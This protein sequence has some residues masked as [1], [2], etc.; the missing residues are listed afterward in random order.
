MGDLA[1]AVLF[2]AAFGLGCWSLLAMTARWGA[3]SLV[4]RVA[5]YI[6]DVVGA[7]AGGA[8]A[9]GALGL[10]DSGGAVL[11]A[12]GARM[13]ERITSLLGGSASVERRLA[14]AGAVGGAGGVERF[15]GRQL[16]WGLLG[17]LAGAMLVVVLAVAG[18]LSAPGLAVPIIAGAGSMALC[19]A[20]LSAVARRRVTRITDELPTVLEFLSL[21]LA[22]GEGLLDSLRRV[23]TVGAGELVGELHTAVIDVGT[24]SSLADALGGISRRLHMP[25]VTR[26]IDQLVAAIERGAP[27]AAVL[28][29]QAVDAREDAK[30]ALIERAGKNEVGMLVPLV[31][32]IL[33]LSVLFAIFPAG[34]LLQLG[35]G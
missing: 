20:A 35:I 4:R 34:Q 24:G 31:F 12:T 10:A 16:V 29:A 8:G 33:P 23:A 1:L 28:Q 5:P 32:L 7:G 21:C 11:R 3:Q 22:A 30:R 18:G 2:G 25:A 14:Q 15:R 6:R 9:G 17:L 27:L 13:R 26:A 19:D